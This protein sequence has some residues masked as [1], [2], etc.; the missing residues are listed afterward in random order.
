MS[1]NPESAIMVRKYR[2][3][4]TTPHIGP[5]FVKAV[6]FDYGNQQITLSLYDIIQNGKIYHDDWLQQMLKHNYPD[7]YLTFAALSGDGH[8]LYR[9]KFTGLLVTGAKQSFDYASSDISSTEIVLNYRNM[10]DEPVSEEVVPVS[11]RE[12][13]IHHSDGSTTFVV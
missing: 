1:N 3:V 11:Q 7:E 6:Y 2:F 9:K 4:L 5:F 10:I 8:E 13:H 12:S